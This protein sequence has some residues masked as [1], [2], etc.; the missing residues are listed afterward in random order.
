MD[1]KVLE[2]LILR[3]HDNT[4]IPKDIR[5]SDYQEYLKWLEKNPQEKTQ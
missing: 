2:H 4:Y 1:Y 3:I 5:N